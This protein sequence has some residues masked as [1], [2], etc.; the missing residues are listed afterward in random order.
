MIFSAQ[1]QPASGVFRMA[2]HSNLANKCKYL[3]EEGVKTA[4]RPYA[5][6]CG[7][8]S[9]RFSHYLDACQ[10]INVFSFIFIELFIRMELQ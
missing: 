6:S 8:K 10:S 2:L 9:T 1:D 4:M 3:V 5:N 7:S